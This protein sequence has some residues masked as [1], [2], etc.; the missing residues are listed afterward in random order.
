MKNILSIFGFGLIAVTLFAESDSTGLRDRTSESMQIKTSTTQLVDTALQS[1]LVGTWAGADDKPGVTSEQTFRNDGTYNGRIVMKVKAQ[2]GL[3]ME[4]SLMFSGI[5]K[6]EGDVCIETTLK[7]EPEI[8]KMPDAPRKYRITEITP[9]EHLS[10][11]IET[12]QSS[13][14]RRKTDR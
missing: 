6:I 1:Y 3:L 4:R 14:N 8:R 10:T 2:S 13:I 11:N 5:W 12:S 9:T 7:V